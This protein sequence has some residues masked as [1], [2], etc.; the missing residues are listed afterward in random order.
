RR[1]QRFT[2]APQLKAHDGRQRTGDE[3][4]G[5]VL[6][7]QADQVSP[8]V[9][10]FELAAA[11]GAAAMAHPRSWFVQTAPATQL[12]AKR[13][14][15]VLEIHEELLVQQPDIFEHGTSIGRRAAACTED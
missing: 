8:V 2:C 15:D 5:Q 14:I 11:A 9:E 6:R 4:S 7:E 10:G 13:E 3:S 1:R 12:R